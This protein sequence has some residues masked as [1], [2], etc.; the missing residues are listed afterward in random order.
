IHCVNP[1]CKFSPNHPI[2]CLPPYCLR[3]CWQCRQYPQNYAP[4]IDGYC[5]TCANKRGV[6]QRR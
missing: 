2:D 1:K 6:N 4:Q 3:T 5:P